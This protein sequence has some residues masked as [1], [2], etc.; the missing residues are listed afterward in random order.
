MAWA[1]PFGIVAG[2][3]WECEP[4]VNLSDYQRQK[5]GALFAAAAVAGAAA[6]GASDAEAWRMLGDRLGE[7]YQV[8]GR[9]A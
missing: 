1:C 8:A 5:T 9:P 2:Q 4:S 6:A 3:A 7:A